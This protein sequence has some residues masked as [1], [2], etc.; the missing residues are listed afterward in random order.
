MQ[1]GWKEVKI[2]KGLLILRVSTWLMSQSGEHNIFFTYL[3][4]IF[5]S[6]FFFLW[7]HLKTSNCT[8]MHQCNWSHTSKHRW[9]LKGKNNSGI[10]NLT[11]LGGLGAKHQTHIYTGSVPTALRTGWVIWGHN[12]KLNSHFFPDNIA[13]WTLITQHCIVIYYF[14][15]IRIHVYLCEVQKYPAAFTSDDYLCPNQKS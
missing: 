11:L 9:T 10:R 13:Y 1:R 8:E 14:P 15:A 12:W 4:I 5:L 3:C 6:S 2:R 7:R